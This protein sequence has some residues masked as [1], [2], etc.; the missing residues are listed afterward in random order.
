ME[1]LF[2]VGDRSKCSRR[3]HFFPLGNSL[4]RGS[5]DFFLPRQL[6]HRAW[7]ELSRGHAEGVSGPWNLEASFL[8]TISEFSP[9]RKFRGPQTQSYMETRPREVKGLCLAALESWGPMH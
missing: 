7:K 8:S 6:R 5:D 3:V 1:G 2:R 9:E 4:G